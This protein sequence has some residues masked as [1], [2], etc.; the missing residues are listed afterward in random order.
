[1]K[2]LHSWRIQTLLAVAF[3]LG[4]GIDSQ[5]QSFLQDFEGGTAVTATPFFT[6]DG[7]ASDGVNSNLAAANLPTVESFAGASDGSPGSVVASLGV[8]ANGG[9]DGSQAAQ[10]LLTNDGT[11]S[12]SFGGI[13]E[14]F[15]FPLSVPSDFTVSADVLAPAGY[16]LSLRVETPFGPSNNGFELTFV[17][18]GS[19][20]TISGVVGTDLISI[21]GGT[22]DSDAGASIVVASGFNGIP[23]GTDQEIF[24]DN[25]SVVRTNA[26]PEPSSAVVLVSLASIVSVSRRRR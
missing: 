10:L 12:I 4:C 7:S 6:H 8:S 5:A 11:T 15:N 3:V 26:I 16:D 22:F 23:V 24:I 9:V 14:F 20:Q 13:V 25:L 17:G 2:W 1:M 21:P 18:T 19:Y